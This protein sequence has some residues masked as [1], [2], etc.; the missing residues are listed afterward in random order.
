MEGCCW[1]SIF[2]NVLSDC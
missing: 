1:Y 2:I